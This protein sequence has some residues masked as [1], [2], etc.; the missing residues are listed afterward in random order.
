MTTKQ[1]TLTLLFT[2]VALV[3]ASWGGLMQLWQSVTLW[4][5]MRFCFFVWLFLLLL[6]IKAGG[7]WIIA[8]IVSDEAG[9]LICVFLTINKIF[10]EWQEME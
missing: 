6:S 5:K 3:A 4:K 2:L 8:A 9:L 1:F 7:G 10:D